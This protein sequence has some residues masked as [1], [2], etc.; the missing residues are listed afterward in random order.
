MGWQYKDWKVALDALDLE[1][2]YTDAEGRAI[3]LRGPTSTPWDWSEDPRS[4]EIIETAPTLDEVRRLLRQAHLAAIR[5][6]GW[7]IVEEGGKAP[8]VVTPLGPRN[9]QPFEL[10]VYYDSVKGGPETALLCVPLSKRYRP[11]FL[12]WRNPNG[13]LEPVVLDEEMRRMMELARRHIVAV[14]PAFAS[15]T[16]MVSLEHY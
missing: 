13:T 14:L 6:I 7:R 16:F 8:S 12:D 3:P 2:E 5:E 1:V 9:L 15:A 10:S 4:I 11:C